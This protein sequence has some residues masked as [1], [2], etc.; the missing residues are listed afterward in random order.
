MAKK[1]AK[2]PRKTTRPGKFESS[3]D[4]GEKLRDI[5]LNGMCEDEC[6]SVTENGHWYGLLTKTGIRGASN[7]IVVESDQGFFDY[8]TYPSAAAARAKFNK[9]ARELAEEQGEFD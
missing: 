9:I 6:G 3:G 8:E 4:I 1:S 5:T 2:R 7:A